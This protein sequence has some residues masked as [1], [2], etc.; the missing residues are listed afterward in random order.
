MA[1]R[2]HRGIPLS[3]L[4]PKFLHTNSTSHTW[5]FSAIAELIDNAYDPDVRAK[6]FWIDWTRIKNLD[7][8]SFMDNG[9]GMTR[10]KL[11][12]MLSFGYSDKKAMRDHVPVG[13][14]GNGFKSGSMRLGKDAIVF[15]KTRDSMS[16]GLLSQSYLQAIKAQ[17]IMVPIITFRRD[18]QNLPEDAASLDAILRHSLFNTVKELFTELRAIS[19]AGCTGTRIIIWNLRMT[20]NGE[21]EFN[22]DADKYDIQ[23]RANASERTRECRAMTPESDYSLRAYCSILYLKPRMQINIRGQRVKTQLI[24]KSL[25]YIANDNYRPSFLTKRI[26]I[27]FGFNTKSKE[28]YGIMMYHKNRLIKAYER[29]SCQ[30][31]V[32]RKG[33]GVI[34]VIECNFLQPT[35]NKQDF[36][37]TDKYRK[38]MHNLSIKLEEYWNE[39]RYKQ[40]KE[41]P[42]CTVPIED[43]M[44]V[45]DQVWVQ[46]DSCLKWRRLPDGFDCSRLPE[47]WFCNMNHDPQ[48]RSCL[49]EEELE[50]QEEEQKSYPKPF[51]RQKRNSKSL[52]DD[53]GPEVLEIPALEGPVNA[54]QLKNSASCKP[55]PADQFSNSATGPLLSSTSNAQRS[56]LPLI[57]LTALSESLK[58][59]KRKLSTAEEMPPAVH[60]M[61]YA[62]FP[63][64]APPQGS[65][66]FIH[67]HSSLAP[68]KEESKWEGMEYEKNADA[69]K[70]LDNKEGSKTY[71]EP[72]QEEDEWHAGEESPTAETQYYIAESH[73]MEEVG[74]ELHDDNEEVWSLQQQ[75]DELMEM[76]KQTAEERDACR[77]ELELL[78]DHCTAVEDE[79]S[80]L[81]SKLERMEEEKASLS[82]LCDQL[83]CKVERLKIE[84]EGRLREDAQSGEERQKLRKLRLNLGRLLV[85][86]VPDLDLKQ[87]DFSSDVI[88]ELLDQ[89][90][91]EVT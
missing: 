25:A 6:Q 5:P 17:Q 26:R 39:I 79:R 12:K 73:S 63:P 41:D 23:I 8:L 87:V 51:K 57:N 70:Q 31:K 7:C 88:D 44:K 42:K 13:V 46:C 65:I 35:H 33:V 34:G 64:N 66:T 85:S 20:T 3:S 40:K 21:T 36:D 32:E 81:L 77:E 89:V 16:V 9:A 47:K 75:Q 80:Q 18:G 83:K 2:K 15:T 69:D 37:D 55:S 30:R 10:A 14:Y 76:M 90:L 22:F 19:T 68:N 4:N 48:F 78:R 45:P 61:P 27:T 49:V 71:Q 86:F 91:K 52:Q 1:T 50:D 29:V 58:R 11:H 38:T 84:K 59:I 43:T 60:P 67:T 62:S 53:H 28:H 82:A 54:R 24:S 72:V 56:P 74:E